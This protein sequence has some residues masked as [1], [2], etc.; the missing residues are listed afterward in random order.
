MSSGVLADRRS[1][2]MAGTASAALAA[3][4]LLPAAGPAVAPLLRLL[5][6]PQ[7]AAAIGRAWL[8]QV[9]ASVESLV[10]DLAADLGAEPAGDPGLRERYAQ[11]VAEDFAT[12]RVER[13]DGWML[14][15]T[16]VRLAALAARTLAA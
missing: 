13:V 15:R 1:V 4:S 9:P 10:A 3:T 2:L 8:Q 14:S 16:E 12:N 6:D 11:R 7:G 5:T